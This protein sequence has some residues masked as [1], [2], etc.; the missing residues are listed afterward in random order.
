MN[1]DNLISSR[2]EFVRRGRRRLI[3]MNIGQYAVSNLSLSIDGPDDYI[4]VSENLPIARLLPG[5]PAA[6][7]YEVGDTTKDNERMLV[8]RYLVEI[9]GEKKEGQTIRHL[10]IV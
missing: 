7:E 4:D 10:S 5:R 9:G 2:V 3:I 6:W 1:T 8:F